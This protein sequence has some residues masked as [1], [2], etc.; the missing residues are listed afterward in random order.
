MDTNGCDRHAALTALAFLPFR[1]VY[2][3]TE[4][5]GRVVAWLAAGYREAAPLE[6]L[7]IFPSWLALRVVFLGGYGLALVLHAA[8]TWAVDAA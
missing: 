7:L 4:R 2:A 1:L 5:V 3:P 6:R 8:G